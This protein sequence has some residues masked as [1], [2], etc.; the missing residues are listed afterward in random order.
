MPPSRSNYTLIQPHSACPRR[1]SDASLSPPCTCTSTRHPGNPTNAY[2]STKRQGTEGRRPRNA[3]GS[4]FRSPKLQCRHQ[5][6][7]FCTCGAGPSAPHVIIAQTCLTFGTKDRKS[8]SKFQPV[9][10]SSCWKM[11]G[12]IFQLLEGKMVATKATPMAHKTTNL[13]PRNV[14]MEQTEP[15]GTKTVPQR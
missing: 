15:T 9:F 10:S 8:W 5:N 3:K 2:Q 1:A 14:T 13:V 7:M 4:H 6:G 12:A 11:E